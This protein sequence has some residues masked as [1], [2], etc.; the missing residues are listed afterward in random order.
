MARFEEEM[1]RE[2]ET[3][4]SHFLSNKQRDM[5][6]KKKK[7]RNLVNKITLML[8]LSNEVKVALK[9][10]GQKNE[11]SVIQFLPGAPPTDVYT[12]APMAKGARGSP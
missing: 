6:R 8:Y 11:R 10:L 3:F 4:L 12:L 1:E 9:A 7:C 2:K 5:R